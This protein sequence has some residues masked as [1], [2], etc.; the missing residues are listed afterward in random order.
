MLTLMECG[1]FET[2]I[3]V[4]SDCVYVAYVFIGT[5]NIAAKMSSWKVLF[6]CIIC[7]DHC[8]SSVCLSV[9]LSV[10]DVCDIRFLRPTSELKA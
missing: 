4:L 5:E 6:S 2:D 7:L 8:S 9:G 1:S 3:S 10:C